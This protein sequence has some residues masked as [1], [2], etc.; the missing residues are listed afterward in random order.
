LFGEVWSHE[1]EI[2]N[3]CLFLNKNHSLWQ[4]VTG[5]SLQRPGFVPRSVHM[6]FV[7]GNV[8]L[9][10]VFFPLQILQGSPV[11]IFPQVPHTHISLIYHS[12][13]IIL[14]ND[15]TVK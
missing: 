2:F 9:G 15:T 1:L 11:G 12:H 7:V 3:I 6:V 5:L 10:L 13:F 14:A 4:L 8:A